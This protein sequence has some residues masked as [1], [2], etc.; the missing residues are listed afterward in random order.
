[1]G[2]KVI[3]SKNRQIGY[4]IFP[5]LTAYMACD[6]YNAREWVWTV[7]IA[8]FVIIWFVAIV[9]MITCEEIDIFEKPEELKALSN[10]E[11]SKFMLR[12]EEELSKK[13]PL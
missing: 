13:K 1:M 10:S 6:F 5:T 9:Q 11:K 7:V 12:M 8:L 2:K 3:S 4:P